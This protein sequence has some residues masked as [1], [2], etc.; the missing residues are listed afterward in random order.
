MKYNVEEDSFGLV[1]GLF[2]ERGCGTRVESRG[3]IFAVNDRNAEAVVH[4]AT[5]TIQQRAGTSQ[6]NSD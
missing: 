3:T 5:E 2:Y 6:R 4:Y 1:P